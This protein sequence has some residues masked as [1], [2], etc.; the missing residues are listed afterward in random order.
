MRVVM[1]RKMSVTLLMA[2]CASSADDSARFATAVMAETS[3]DGAAVGAT[4]VA[5]RMSLRVRPLARM[6][7]T[8]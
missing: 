7:D 5:L 3:T 8:K 6:Q 2:V 1:P 4:G